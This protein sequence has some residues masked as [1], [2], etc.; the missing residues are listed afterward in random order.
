MQLLY[1]Y[2]AVKDAQG[3]RVHGTLDKRVALEQ[4]LR[5][6]GLEVIYSSEEAATIRPVQQSSPSPQPLQAI[7]ATHGAP[8]DAGEIDNMKTREKTMTNDN[9]RSRLYRVFALCSSVAFASGVCAQGVAQQPT[10]TAAQPADARLEEVVITGSRV[11]TNGNDSP[12]PVTVV[13]TEELSAVHPGN[14]VEA[15][16]D[17]PLFNGSRGQNTNP[18]NNGAAGSPA[19]AANA[20]NQLNLRQ[21]GVLR[22]LIL[23]DGHR[24]PPSTA[25]GTVDV[26]TIPQM[27]LQRVDV[28]TGGVSAVYGSDGVVGAVNFVTDTKFQGVK[29]NLEAGRSDYGDAD[30]SEVGIAFG[31]SLFSD[32]GHLLGSFENRHQAP[33]ESKF[34]RPWGKNVYT[35]QGFGTAAQPYYQVSGARQSNQTF[36]GRVTA[37]PLASY[38][39]NATDGT[40]FDTGGYL[41]PFVRG[42]RLGLAPTYNASGNCGTCEIGGDGGYSEGQLRAGLDMNQFYGRFDFDFTDD[43]HG[44]LTVADTRNRS[45]GRGNGYTSGNYTITRDNAFLQPQYR[46]ALGTSPTVNTT[47]T[48]GKMFTEI[49]RAYTETHSDQ[50]FGV[51]GLQG[52]LGDYKW[53]VAYT[54]SDGSIDVRQNMAI[55]N[56]RFF[57]ALDSVP[58]GGWVNGLPVGVPV[59]R[60]SQTNAA[61]AGCVPLNPFGQNAGSQAAIDYFI[62]PVS[63]KTNIGMDD[64]AA[65]ITGAPFST[66]A[67]PVNAALSGE[68]RK[69]SYE[70]VSGTPDPTGPIRANCAGI[71]AGCTATT[72]VYT[73][74]VANLA[75]T[76]QTVKE[77]AVELNVP[78]LKDKSFAKSLDMSAAYRIA[79]YDTLSDNA[80]T[81]KVG[82]TWDPFDSLTVRATRSRDFR[83]PSLDETFRTLVAGAPART[84][85]DSLPGNPDSPLNAN[86]S[87][88]N[89]GNPNL[90]PEVGD[91]FSYG[92]VWRAT[93]NFDITVDAFNIKIQDAIFVVQGNTPAYQ[94]SCYASGGTSVS[95][96]PGNNVY[97]NLIV[98]DSTNHVIQWLQKPFNLAELDTWGADIELGYKTLIADKP[99]SLRLL[100]TYQPHLIYKQ[101]GLADAD[102]AGAWFGTNG[103][104]SNPVW[105][106][107]LFASF[108]PIDSLTIAVQERWRSSMPKVDGFPEWAAAP[109]YY[110]GSAIKSIAYT[111]LNLTFSPKLDIGKLDFFVTVQNLFNTDPPQAGFW[112][113][114]NPGQFGEVLAGDDIIGR[115]YTAGIRFRM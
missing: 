17:M 66:W 70:I 51:A 105:R 21:M 103:L 13:T 62:H 56:G 106:A 9:S 38:L 109:A 4:M 20:T 19:G 61:Y 15:M 98:R 57:A 28:V 60:A 110:S 8:V 43:L 1:Q 54:Y 99:L 95:N 101:P 18:G 89:S 71:A 29:V 77:A 48:L 81:W 42:T 40:R 41:V 39:G 90:K 5:N 25:D 50:L 86:A 115:Y 65:S 63:Y 34:D 87:S 30:T 49:P 45:T 104:Q 24:A 14:L 53:D 12:T 36:G 37:G 96:N 73:A 33:L 107:T 6:T 68:W 74:S 3:G 100:T 64:V 59:C 84:F 10:S 58:S 72:T 52:T 92:F 69:L 7:E 93:P 82:M 91:T 11:I 75:E 31:T 112:G 79:N 76:T 26:N 35:L 83:A 47:F 80:N 111:N 67:G 108:K 46:N 44:Y 16:N 22:T 85:S 114:P 55:D 113:N 78:L 23:Y 32:R 88:V 2:S 94:N 27:L 97:C 102:Y